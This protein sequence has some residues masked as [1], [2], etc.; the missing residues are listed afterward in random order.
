MSNYDQLVSLIDHLLVDCSA[1]FSI[2]CLQKFDGGGKSPAADG[3]TKNY[4][5][6]Y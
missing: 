6:G 1:I 3:C 2:L 5:Y 4:S